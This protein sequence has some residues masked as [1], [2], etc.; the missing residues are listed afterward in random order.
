MKRRRMTA[1]R[2]G[3]LGR[4]SQRLLKR[5]VLRSLRTVI[6]LK[7]QPVGPEDTRRSRTSDECPWLGIFPHLPEDRYQRGSEEGVLRSQSRWHLRP[8][9]IVCTRAVAAENSCL[10]RR[11]IQP[12]C[13]NRTSRPRWDNQR[14]ASL[15]KEP[16]KTQSGLDLLDMSEARY[17]RPIHNDR[18]DGEHH[19]GTKKYQSTQDVW[20]DSPRW[21]CAIH[22]SRS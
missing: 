22:W 12:P 21:D 6:G 2:A 16:S 8:A 10:S 19:G 5:A 7:L 20:A 18:A 3:V 14:C 9:Q 4:R 17:H 11:T 13:C 1:D 15:S